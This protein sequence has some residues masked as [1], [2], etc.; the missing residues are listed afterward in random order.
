MIVINIMENSLIYKML[1][2]ANKLNNL[3]DS[4]VAADALEKNPAKVIPICIVDKKLLGSSNNF[5]KRMAFLLFSSQ[6][7]LILC[8][9]T[10]TKAISAAA[11]NPLISVR[12]S[13]KN[14]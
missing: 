7:E 8:L 11:K 10:D 1:Y 6:R 3:T 5:L 12:I 14:S 9:L 13:I 4:V 2:G